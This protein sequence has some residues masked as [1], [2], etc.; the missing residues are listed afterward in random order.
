MYMY[1]FIYLVVVIVVLLLLTVYAT[2]VNEWHCVVIN[3]FVYTMKLGIR[4]RWFRKLYRKVGRMFEPTLSVDIRLILSYINR[5]FV[6]VLAYDAQQ[7]GFH[8][9]HFKPYF[10]FSTNVWLREV[11]K[12]LFLTQHGRSH[13]FYFIF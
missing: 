5:R 12:K 7:D 6:S 13:W 11:P 1:A 3:V 10:I 9:S 8:R 4:K 2:V